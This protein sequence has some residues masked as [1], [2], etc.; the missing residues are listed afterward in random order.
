MEYVQITPEIYLGMQPNQDVKRE[1]EQLGVTGSINLRREFDDRAHGLAFEHHCYLPTVDF[2]TPSL[3]QLTE[4]VSFIDKVLARGGK[5]YIHCAAGVGRAPTMAAAY[6][7]S[8][9]HG[10][11]E[12]IA[13][14][15][16]KR[17]FI[18]LTT[19]Q[20]EQLHHFEQKWSG[21]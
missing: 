12:A 6:L 14:I 2:D 4:G 17:P 9:G 18:D 19:E 7:I 15:Q 16:T 3:A 1:L 8:Q 20:R 13:L 11:D 21:R 10:P 5:V